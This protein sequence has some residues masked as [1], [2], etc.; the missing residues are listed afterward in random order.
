[1]YPI[2]LT[3]GSFH[4]RAYGL[5]IAI[6]LLAGAWLAG[7]EAARKGISPE[8]VQDFI[9]WA[10][11]SGMLGARLYYVAFAVPW[12]W[13]L[14]RP[15]PQPP[16]PLCCGIRSRLPGS[17]RDDPEPRLAGKGG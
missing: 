13:D 6:A 11:L 14:S 16:R 8:R 5:V 1:M 10:S 7:R 4:V 9:V 2:L 3:I 12:R 17:A 15:D